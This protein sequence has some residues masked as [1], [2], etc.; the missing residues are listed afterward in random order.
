MLLKKEREAV[1]MYS[2]KLLS[3]GLVKGSGGNISLCNPEKTMMGVTPS[4]VGYDIMKLEDVVV[5]DLNGRKIEGDL[6][7]TSE[8][9]FH[10]ALQ[11]LRPEI[12]A[13][14]H[15]HSDYATA[16]ACL[17]W[18]LPA[19][20]YLIGFAG[21]KVSVVPYATYGTQELSDNICSVMCESNAV[22]IANH[23]PV[24][25]GPSLEMAFTTAEMLEYVSRLYL[26]SKSVGE[27]VILDDHQMDEVMEK[28]KNYGQ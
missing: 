16:L 22:L 19:I 1:L 21:K 28:F 4:G 10:L 9:A 18:E 7:P 11:N 23:G 6:E 24:C 14:V 5:T 25:V 13:V 17:G 27:P 15:T 26:L 20:H 8:I 2:K 12:H 3:A